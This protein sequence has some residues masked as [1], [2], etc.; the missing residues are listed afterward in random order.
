LP[1]AQPMVMATTASNDSTSGI[2][3]YLSSPRTASV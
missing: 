1:G 2:K 3:A